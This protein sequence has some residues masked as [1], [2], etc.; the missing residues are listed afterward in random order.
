M[1]RLVLHGDAYIDATEA[2]F[3]GGADGTTRYI[4]NL[5]TSSVVPSIYRGTLSVLF[6]NVTV[7]TD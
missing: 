6:D 5:T 2:V 4:P 7:V 1:R 3:L